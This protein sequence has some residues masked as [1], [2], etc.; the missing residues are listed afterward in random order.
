MFTSN[1]ISRSKY[2]FGSFINRHD[3]N[4]FR[5]YAKFKDDNKDC[6]KAIVDIPPKKDEVCPGPCERRKKKKGI[7]H[8]IKL[9]IIEGGTNFGSMFLYC[10]MIK[11][12]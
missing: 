6:R 1:L 4:L 8:R 2:L 9:K 11:F 3:T 7:L 5:Y 12:V 10:F